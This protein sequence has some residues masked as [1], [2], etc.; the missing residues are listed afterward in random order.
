[1]PNTSQGHVFPIHNDV[2][3]DILSQEQ[4]ESEAAKLGVILA[5]ARSIK[6]KLIADKKVRQLVESKRGGK[7]LYGNSDA[8]L[9]FFRNHPDEY[10]L[11]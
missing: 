7:S 8:I 9:D 2:E 6:T 10:K 1:M 3:Y 5:D 4:Y 11:I